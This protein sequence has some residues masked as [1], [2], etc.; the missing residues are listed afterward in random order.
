MTKKI[1]QPKSKKSPTKTTKSASGE[2]QPL[3]RQPKTRSQKYL[4]AKKTIKKAKLY[5][6][7]KAIKLA[8]STSIS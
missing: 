6:L 3:V 5:P 2:K 1:L 7:N 4:E 8:Q